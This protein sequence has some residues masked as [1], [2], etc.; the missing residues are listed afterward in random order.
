MTVTNRK[1][2]ESQLMASSFY[3]MGMGHVKNHVLHQVS[4]IA[5]I[6]LRWS[7]GCASRPVHDIQC[8][9]KILLSSRIIRKS[10]KVLKNCLYTLYTRATENVQRQLCKII[11]HEAVY[12]LLSNS[13]ISST[14][15]Q[16]QALFRAAKKIKRD[17][18]FC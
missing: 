5:V 12:R 14:N 9:F 2:K 4:P 15:R 8:Y 13:M 6:W 16:C 1:K 10:S 17:I 7:T 11:L 3:P 18:L